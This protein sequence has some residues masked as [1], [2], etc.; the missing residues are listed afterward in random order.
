MA[1]MASLYEETTRPMTIRELC[2]YCGD[3]VEDCIDAGE[4]NYSIAD[5]NC[6]SCNGICRCDDLYDDYK[7][8]ILDDSL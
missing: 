8:S 4:C 6:A 2:G 5:D 3:T 7:E 1:K